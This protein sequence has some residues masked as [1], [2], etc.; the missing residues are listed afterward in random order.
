[1]F[2]LVFGAAAAADEV[3]AV[4]GVEKGRIVLV[5]DDGRDRI[6]FDGAFLQAFAALEFFPAEVDVVEEQRENDTMAQQALEDVLDRGRRRIR[7]AGSCL[8]AAIIVQRRLFKLA[9]D[10][11]G[12]EEIIETNLQRI[13]FSYR[14]TKR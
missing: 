10:A 1:M 8:A 3:V 9:L 2:R 12:G 13:I 7:R 6:R 14:G 4:A 5:V 11:T